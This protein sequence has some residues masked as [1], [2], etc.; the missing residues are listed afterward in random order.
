M[1]LNFIM[2]AMLTMSSFIFPL[3]TFPYI[4]RILLP[5]GTGKVAL[6]TSLIS[7]FAMFAQLGIPTY[8]IRACAK[9]RDNKEELGRTVQELF[10][11]NLITSA[12]TYVAF[13]I[14]LV[15]VDKIW[16]E[17]ELYIITSLSIVFNT[18]GME[19]LYKALE[20]YTYITVRS[21]LFKFI[22]LIAMFILVKEQKD[23]IIYGAISIFAASA[24][25]LLNF[26]NIRKYIIWKP[27]GKYKIKRHLKAVFVFFAMSCA[28]TIYTNLDTIML[29][30]MTN[31]TE[32]GYYNA[33]VKIKIILVSIVTSLGAVLLPRASYYIEH[34]MLD[35]FWEI[36]SKALNF[37]CVCATPLMVYFILFARNG[38]FFLSGA[39]YEGSVIPMQFIM[40][41]LLFIGLTNILGIQILIP[42]GKEKIVLYSEIAGAVV[43]LILNAVLIPTLASTGAAI[44][45][46]VA[47]AVVFIVQ[48]ISLHNEV[49]DIFRG[50]RYLEI[51]I[52]I[53]LGSL[54]CIWVKNLHFGD[55]I[56]LVI[57]SVC[58]FIVYMLVLV[59]CKEPLLNELKR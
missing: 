8:G 40:P 1:K 13:I 24:S 2:N 29:G 47:E 19:W 12:I 15:S 33:A 16:L 9:I 18:I 11:I 39:S 53:C 59:I 22:A 54:G 50:I 49:S 46:L 27:L 48:Y 45:T 14:T 37:V 41:T 30:F 21:I 36:S 52:A 26:I 20:Q 31:N 58:F 17:K 43:D 38:I 4:S 42:L 23:Y 6:A 34:K 51:F 56:T 3:I 57:S 44:G 28:T 25:G 35:K 7:Y 55:F 32:V 10:I 5:E